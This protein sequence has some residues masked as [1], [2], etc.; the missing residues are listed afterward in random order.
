MKIMLDF[1][2]AFAKL[3][4]CSGQIKTLQMLMWL[5]E[6]FLGKEGVTGSIPVISL[7]SP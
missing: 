3:S 7:Q 2:G 6:H 4:N 1:S 5:R